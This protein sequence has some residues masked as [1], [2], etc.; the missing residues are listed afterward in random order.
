M[1]NV[2]K[3]TKRNKKVTFTE[4]QSQ[5]EEYICHCAVYFTFRLS[6]WREERFWQYQMKMNNICH[7][8]NKNSWKVTKTVKSIIF[9]LEQ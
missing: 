2:T 1:I 3:V 8:N 9:K 4:E 5:S 6:G 7:F